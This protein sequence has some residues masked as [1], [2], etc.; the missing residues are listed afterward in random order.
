MRFRHLLS[1][2]WKIGRKHQSPRADSLVLAQSFTRFELRFAQ[3]VPPNRVEN[4]KQPKHSR[5]TLL[6]LPQVAT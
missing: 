4:K 1:P 2:L 3:I 6:V 5:N